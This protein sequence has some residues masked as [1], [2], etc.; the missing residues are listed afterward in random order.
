MMMHFLMVDIYGPN[1]IFNIIFG[2]IQGC[3]VNYPL[4]GLFEFLMT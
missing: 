2:V 1:E 4:N 3:L